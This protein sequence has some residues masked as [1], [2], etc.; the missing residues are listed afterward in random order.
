MSTPALKKRADIQVLRCLNEE[1]R[2]LLAYEV[3]ATN[4]L[5]VDL[6]WTAR[7]DGSVRYFPCPRCGGRNVVEP[8]RSD[9]GEI[10]QRVTRW[11]R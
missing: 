11:Q 5:Y 9:K 10:V 6:S 3:D 8:S 2:G 7:S 1:C 4:T